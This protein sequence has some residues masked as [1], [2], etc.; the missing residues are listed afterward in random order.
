MH[1]LWCVSGV[2]GVGAGFYVDATEQPWANGYRMFSYISSELPSVINTNFGA[3][4][5]DVSRSGIFGHSMGGHG[6]LICALKSNGAYKVCIYRTH[7]TA[8]WPVL[9][10][11]LLYCSQ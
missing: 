11:W 3:S 2:A 5:A 6:A 7:L 8:E 9:T 10:C 4:Q 1:C